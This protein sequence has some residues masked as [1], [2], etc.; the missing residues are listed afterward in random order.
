MPRDIRRLPRTCPLGPAPSPPVDPPELVE[1]AL[2]RSTPGITTDVSCPC[3]LQNSR[4]DWATLA[5]YR[6]QIS[7]NKIGI[8]TPPTSQLTVSASTSPA[9]SIFSM[10]TLS[11]SKSRNNFSTTVAYG[12]SIPVM[13]RMSTLQCFSDRSFRLE[14]CQ[15]RKK[16]L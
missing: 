8:A 14:N 5:G 13:S 9:R 15:S 6:E 4:I 12:L 11:L 1:N 7:N 16:G 3:P 10:V 2:L